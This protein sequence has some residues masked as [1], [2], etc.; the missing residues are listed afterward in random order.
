M[1]PWNTQTVKVILRGKKMLEVSTSQTSNYSQSHSKKNGEGVA[2]KQTHISVQ[3]KQRAHKPNTHTCWLIP[4]H[5]GQKMLPLP[6]RKLSDN[7]TAV[8]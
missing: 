5:V 8:Q 2:Q 1:E 7:W 6:I 3:E 4:H